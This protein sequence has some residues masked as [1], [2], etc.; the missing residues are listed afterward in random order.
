MAPKSP[1]PPKMQ[2]GGAGPQAELEGLV[3]TQEKLRA[4]A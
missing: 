2:M 3:V 4:A 1:P